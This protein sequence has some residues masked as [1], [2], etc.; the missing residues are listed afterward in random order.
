MAL[1]FMDGFDHYA[2]AD[3]NKKWTT[4]SVGDISGTYGRTGNGVQLSTRYHYM[5]K[6]VSATGVTTIVVGFD[7][8]LTSSGYT[9]LMGFIESGILQCSLTLE[10]GNKIGFRRGDAATGSTLLAT[11]T[12]VLSSADWQF[13]EV[14][15]TFSNTV[16]TAEVRVNGVTDI[17]L[18]GIDSC[19]NANEYC[20]GIVL[21]S[22][23]SACLGG[24][25]DN[26]YVLDSTGSENNNFLGVVSINTVFPTAEGTNTGWTPLSGTDNAL[27]VDETSQ[28]GDTTYNYSDTV[29][30]RDT[31]AITDIT[32]TGA[33]VF[34]VA[35]NAM[36]R[37]DGDADR[38]IKPTLK[39]SATYSLG[40][41]VTLTTSYLNTQQI[42]NTDP[43]TSAAWTETNVNAIEA[44]ID[45]SA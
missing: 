6:T 25:F 43:N 40:T 37:K 12:A 19:S 16:G 45:V 23:N 1:L 11:G 41:E 8:K 18:T 35:V 44:G 32:S 34:G 4:A 42:Y 5:T 29:S 24:Y 38:K 14:K 39:S 31:Y 17:T 2:A 26:V 22:I 21:G 3:A 20:T 36:V 30:A 15:V 13:I 28:D 7:Y 27:M 9:T 10:T 33:E